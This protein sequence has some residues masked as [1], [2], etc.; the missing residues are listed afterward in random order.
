MTKR[1]RYLK[2]LRN[3][4]VD[5]LV[6]APNFDYWLRVNEAEGTMPQKFKGMDRNDIVRA[7]GAYIWNRAEGLKTVYDRNIKETWTESK[8]ATVQ[9]FSTPLGAI[10][11]VWTKSEGEHRSKFLSEHL[12]K[13]IETLKIVKYVYEGT[14]YEP[15]YEPTQ[16]ALKETGED[17]VVLH[18]YFCVPFIEYSKTLAGYINGFYLWNDYREQVDSLIDVIFKNFVEGYKVLSDGPA[19]I[20]ATGDNMDG[21]TI[22][23]TI[24]K[25]YAVP[26]YQEIRKFVNAK[27]KIF[28]GHWCGRTQN[29]LSHTPGCGLDVVEAIVTSPMADISLS[30]ALD[31]LK[32]EV[33]LQGGLPAVLVC[34]E[35]GDWKKFED[36]ISNIILPLRGKKGFILGMAD[37]VPPN[38]DFSR[39]EAIASMI[40]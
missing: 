6:W 12:I 17:G 39:V 36:Y 33:V 22:S 34:H 10:R 21:T 18:S 30:Q 37:N 11:Q 9:E 24:F 8:E 28:E 14:H 31:A 40:Q 16:R 19:D 3:E 7:I 32:G 15:W 23:P 4:S 2:A 27:G 20:I 13:D 38:A 26:F 1:E 29:L 35:G 25:E 5:Q